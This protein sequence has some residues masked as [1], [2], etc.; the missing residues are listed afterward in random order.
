MRSDEEHGGLIAIV[1]GARLRKAEQ[2]R[3]LDAL[4]DLW[5]HEMSETA[6]T[7]PFPREA[8]FEDI[9]SMNLNLRCQRRECVACRKAILTTGFM[10]FLALLLCA[11]LAICLAL[12]SMS[13]RGGDEMQ[14]ARN[15]GAHDVVRQDHRKNETSSDG[16]P[17][18]APGG[19]FLNGRIGR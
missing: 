9:G 16:N 7:R 4:F 11:L 8:G 17:T 12:T 3:L 14:A 1:L 19:L 10:L 2:G 15:S 5:R 13:A 18:N 6:R